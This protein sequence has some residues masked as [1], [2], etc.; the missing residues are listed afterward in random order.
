VWG[1]WGMGDVHGVDEYSD[2]DV[3]VELCF[4]N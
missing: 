4:F 3:K 2:V 1:G